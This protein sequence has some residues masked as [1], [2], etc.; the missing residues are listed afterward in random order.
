M[1]GGSLVFNFFMLLYFFKGNIDVWVVLGNE[2]WDFDFF[3]FY[4]CKFV[5]VYIFFQLFKDFCGLIYY[6]E[7]FVK[8]D[9][10][11]YVIFSEG[12]NVIN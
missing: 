5:I 10:F 11:I 6:N 2:G 9:G 1:F 12:Y 8:G 7:D 4:L 3:V